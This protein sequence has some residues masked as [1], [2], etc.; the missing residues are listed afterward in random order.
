MFCL[1]SKGV[2]TCFEKSETIKT[3]NQMYV[4]ASGKQGEGSYLPVAEH[5]VMTLAKVGHSVVI[6]KTYCPPSLSSL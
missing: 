5:P 1:K 2:L 6:N 4:W 3:K